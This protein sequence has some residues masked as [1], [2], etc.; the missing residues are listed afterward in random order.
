MSHTPCV[1]LSHCLS[2]ALSLSLSHCLCLRCVFVRSLSVCLPPSTRA[3]AV[4]ENGGILLAACIRT[5]GLGMPSKISTVDKYQ[6][7]QN[8]FVLLSLVKTK[9]VGHVRD[10]RR[11]VVALSRSR[12]G[13]Y[14][15]GKK[16]RRRWT[17]SGREMGAEGGCGSL[18][19]VKGLW[20][21]ERQRQRARASTVTLPCPVALWLDL[22]SLAH[23][24]CSR[25]SLPPPPPGS[26]SP[27]PGG[28]LRASPPRFSPLS[29][30]LAA[31]Y[32]GSSGALQQL[33]RTGPVLCAA[34][35]QAESPAAR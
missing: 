27:V 25:N 29:Y 19:R 11:L 1:C 8:D 18:W 7:Q 6:G 13:L 23:R 24:V 28:P 10:V 5:A 15:F 3:R 26:W 16:V 30:I 17:V 21:V 4:P 31:L 14:I 33:H 32:P 35:L 22:F 20:C 2:R 34:Q 9:N 12:L